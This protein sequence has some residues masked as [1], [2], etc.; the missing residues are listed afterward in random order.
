MAGWGG[1]EPLFHMGIKNPRL[2]TP[3]ALNLYED[4]V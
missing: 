3:G 2:H 4:P 1:R